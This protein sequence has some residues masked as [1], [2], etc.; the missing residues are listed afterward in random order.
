MKISV[1]KGAFLG[2][3]P[4]AYKRAITWNPGILA[5]LHPF[6][7]AGIHIERLKF[8]RFESIPHVL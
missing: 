6:K 7:V 4:D 8:Q 1:Y 5:L 3:N 2:G